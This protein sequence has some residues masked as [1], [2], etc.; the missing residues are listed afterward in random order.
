MNGTCTGTFFGSPPP[1][2]MGRG[3]QFSHVA[4]QIKREEQYTEK[5]I[6]YN[7]TSDLGMG[8][9]GQLPLDFFEMRWDLRWLAI[10]CVLVLSLNRSPFNT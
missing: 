5:K 3:Q 10:E 4:H 8:S 2:A 9:K 6:P 1:G 7:Q